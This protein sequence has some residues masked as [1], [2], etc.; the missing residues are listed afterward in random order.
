[1]LPPSIFLILWIFV[2]GVERVFLK[3]AF[4]S[5]RLHQS[6]AIKY[7]GGGSQR[8]YKAE[9]SSCQH[10]WQ[11][12]SG[13]PPSDPWSQSTK[14]GS[15]YLVR[16]LKSWLKSTNSRF[17]HSSPC[18]RTLHRPFPLD[19]SLNSRPRNDHCSQLTPS[20]SRVGF[21]YGPQRSPKALIWIRMIPRTLVCTMACTS[22]RPPNRTKPPS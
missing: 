22:E 5:F 14:T 16:A 17:G 8:I 20:Y 1:M 11:P 4:F 12:S 3:R 7:S 19:R 9:P 2:K 13:S 18:D 10:S 21:G 6:S 15:G